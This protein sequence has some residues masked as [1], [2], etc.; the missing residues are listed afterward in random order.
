MSKEINYQE[1]I[2]NCKLV[3]DLVGKNGLMKKWT[4][5]IANCGPILLQ[6]EIIFAERSEIALSI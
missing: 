6:F 3:E 4:S 5:P 1:E 2:K